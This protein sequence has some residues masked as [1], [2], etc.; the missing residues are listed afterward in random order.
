MRDDNGSVS[1]RVPVL[2]R[3]DPEEREE[4]EA[5]ASGWKLSL[6]GTVRRLIQERRREDDPKTRRTRRRQP[7]A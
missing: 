2:V 1:Q 5:L 4:L 7:T 3:L 6:A